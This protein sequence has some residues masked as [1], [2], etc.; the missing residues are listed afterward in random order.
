[1]TDKIRPE[2]AGTPRLDKWMTKEDESIDPGE[3]EALKPASARWFYPKSIDFNTSH[4]GWSRVGGHNNF[5]YW[6]DGDRKV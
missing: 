3:I 5:L 6:G 4:F 2:G 1:M